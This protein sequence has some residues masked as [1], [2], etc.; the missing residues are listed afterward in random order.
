[1]G[2]ILR[3]GSEEPILVISG[4]ES[5]DQ[6][7]LRLCFPDSSSDIRAPLWTPVRIGVGFQGGQCVVGLFGAECWYE[8]E[9]WG[10]PPS[11][12]I[13]QKFFHTCPL[14]RLLHTCLLLH[15]HRGET[16]MHT[17]EAGLGFQG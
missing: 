4:S 10:H 16:H 6:A 15:I 5:K 9:S 17:Q 2:G 14:P 8:A 7:A 3:H 1:M 13:S 12:P 11:P